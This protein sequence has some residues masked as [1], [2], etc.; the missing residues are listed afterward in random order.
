MTGGAYKDSDNTEILQNKYWTV[1]PHGKLPG[2]AAITGLRLATINNEVFS[3]GNYSIQFVFKVI[4]YSDK[5]VTEGYHHVESS[6]L[7][8]S[9]SILMMADGTNNPIT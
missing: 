6:C 4:N 2:N 3:F 9:N 8:S 5:V 7:Q 1:L